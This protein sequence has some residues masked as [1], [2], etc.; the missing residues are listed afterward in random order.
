MADMPEFISTEAAMNFAPEGR[1]TLP[2]GFLTARHEERVLGLLLD[3]ID[4]QGL[5]ISATASIA[6]RLDEPSSQDF[7]QASLLAY[8]PG[9]PGLSGELSRQLIGSALALDCLEKTQEFHSRL[10]TARCMTLA[11]CRDPSPGRARGG[12]HIEV[13]SGVWRDLAE[14]TIV[15]IRALQSATYDLRPWS[16]FRSVGL[17]SACANGKS[18]CVMDDGTIEIRGWV[19][20]RRHA[21]WTVAWSVKLLTGPQAT[22]AQIVNISLSGF[23]LVTTEPLQ[24]SEHICVALPNGE[25]LSGTIQWVRVD[26]YGIKFVTP[27]RFTDP[28]AAAARSEGDR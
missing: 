7:M 24:V 22:I 6:N 1:P 13:L 18:P 14:H 11:F 4:T 8:L 27:M 16:S 17:L 3:A 15:V 10:A 28:I 23:A 12:V 26:H 21:R 2:S 19:E 20:R 9:E 5:L 25:R